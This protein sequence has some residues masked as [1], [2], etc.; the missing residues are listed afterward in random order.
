MVLFEAES[1][2]DSG[3]IFLRDCIKL[4]G[5]ELLLE[6]KHKQGKKTLE[7]VLKFLELWPDIEGKPQ[8]GKSSFFPRRTRKDDM[9][10][11][12][13]T[14]VENFNHLR[15]TDNEN[16]PAWFEHRGRKYFLKIYPFE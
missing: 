8:K 11:K 14:I 9:L 2:L 12:N 3:Q 5:S 13:K 10:D 7:L 16:Y 15:I 6:I 1:G 4:D